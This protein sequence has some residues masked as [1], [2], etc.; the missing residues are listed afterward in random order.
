MIATLLKIV[1]LQNSV[2]KQQ[3]GHSFWMSRRI[4][5]IGA[6]NCFAEELGA[7]IKL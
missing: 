6:S 2:F 4:Q 1:Q 3:N 5:V 7:C